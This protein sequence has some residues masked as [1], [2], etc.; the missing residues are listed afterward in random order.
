M[1][2][3][4]SAAAVAPDTAW[5]YR[6]TVA[7]RLAAAVAGG[8]LLTAGATALLSLAL[9]GP[10][11]SA[12]LT[13]TMLSFSIFTAA[14]MTA[15]ATSSAARAWLWLALPGALAAGAAWWLSG[16]AS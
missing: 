5:R 11:A 16:S 6:L 7:S 15:F 9:P 4:S 14:V 13:A 3:P 1:P 8:Y 10:R 12:V 2:K